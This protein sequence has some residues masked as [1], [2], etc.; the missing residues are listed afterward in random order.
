MYSLLGEQGWRSGEGTSLPP[1][2]LRFDSQTQWVEFVVV[3]CLCS[4]RLFS[5]YSGFPL[6]SKRYISKFQFDLEGHPN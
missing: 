4:K 2:W 5:G 6:S 1:V 3:S